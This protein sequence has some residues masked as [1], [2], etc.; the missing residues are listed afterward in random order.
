MS[1]TTTLEKSFDLVGQIMA[2]ESGELD[3]DE[4]VQLFQHMIDDGTVWHLQGSYGRMAVRLIEAGLCH[5]RS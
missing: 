2:Y 4:T 5:K 1:D 3:Q